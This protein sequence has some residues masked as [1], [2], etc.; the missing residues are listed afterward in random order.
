LTGARRSGARSIRSEANALAVLVAFAFAAA[1]ACA[2]DAAR[3]SA[4]DS[5]QRGVDIYEAV[6][7][8]CHA[9]GAKGAP[10]VGDRAAW[11]ARAA[12]GLAGLTRSALLGIRDMPPHGGDQ[13]LGTL[14]LQRAI[15]YMVNESGG[16]W[17]EPAAPRP[18]RSGAQVVQAYCALCHA[19]GFDGAPRI[20]D[21]AAWLPRTVLGI[22][23]LVRGAVRGHNAMPPRGGQ[24]SLTDAELRGAV[25][26]M[27]SSA[28]ARAAADRE[29]KQGRQAG[30]P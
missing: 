6:C 9:S 11:S 5:G 3:D 20:G 26:Y 4:Q 10:R 12:R 15:V 1:P 8:N 7:S 29:A 24:P 30:K 28:R 13:S 19:P 23:P 25:I 18:G 27:I 17:A 22:D 16:H 21:R 2:Q 14:E